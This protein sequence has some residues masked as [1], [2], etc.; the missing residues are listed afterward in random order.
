MSLP[1]CSFVAGELSGTH[2]RSL[3][4]PPWLRRIPSVRLGT[5]TR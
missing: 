3:P 5:F 1:F 2:R 4:F